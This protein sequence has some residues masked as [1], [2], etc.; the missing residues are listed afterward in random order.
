MKQGDLII[1]ES[2]IILD[3]KHLFGVLHI[4]NDDGWMRHDDP[5]IAGHRGAQQP[6]GIVFNGE[7]FALIIFRVMTRNEEG[8]PALCELVPHGPLVLTGGDEF[9]AAYVKEEPI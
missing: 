7:R 8:R 6:T 4:Q 5:R 2:K 3:V 9:V 1:L